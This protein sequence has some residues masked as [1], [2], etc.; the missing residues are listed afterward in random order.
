MA[1]TRTLLNNGP[2][3]FLLHTYLQSDGFEGELSNFVIADPTVYD[4]VLTDKVIQ[5]NMKLTLMQVW[6]SFNWFDGLI[7]FD[8]LNPV[9]CWMLPRDASNYFDFR[10]F[11]GLANRLVDPQTAQVNERTGKILLS[12]SGYAPIGSTGTMVI[13]VRKSL[14]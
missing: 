10:Y 6:Y 2:R 8:Q 14:D 12:T 5:P 13:E 9:P 11:G 4:S 1:V 3:S 7:S